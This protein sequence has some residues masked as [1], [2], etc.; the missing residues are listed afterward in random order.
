MIR[1][2]LV[3]IG[4]VVWLIVMVIIMAVEIASSEH[5]ASTSWTAPYTAANGMSCCHIGI[6]CKKGVVR[7]VEMGAD[8]SVVEV[9]GVTFIFP[10]KSIHQSEELSGYYCLKYGTKP[11]AETV[12]CIFYV[13]AS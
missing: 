10:T 9:D 5:T 6:D 7:I 12:R 1:G 3:M 8:E 11:S 13:I 2:L 4:W